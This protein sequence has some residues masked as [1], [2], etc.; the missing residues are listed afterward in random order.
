MSLANQSQDSGT[1]PSQTVVTAIADYEGVEPTKIVATLYEVIDPE[2][3]D[4]LFASGDG[5]TSR[6]AGSVSFDYCGYEVTVGADGRVW[7]DETE[8]TP[9]FGPANI[10]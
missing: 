1:S 4:A 9:D 7:L 5:T 2:A 6:Y 8:V 10:Q 3:L